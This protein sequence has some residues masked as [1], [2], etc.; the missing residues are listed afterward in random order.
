MGG[1]TAFASD[2]FVS[3]GGSLWQLPFASGTAKDSSG[4]A[5]LGWALPLS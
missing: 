2:L 3:S 1:T 4:H 5:I